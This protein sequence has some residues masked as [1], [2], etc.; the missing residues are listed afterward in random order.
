MSIPMVAQMGIR[1]LRD[2]LALETT[3]SSFPGV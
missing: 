3:E 2:S 1:S